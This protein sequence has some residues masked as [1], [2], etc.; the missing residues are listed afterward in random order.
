MT[1]DKPEARPWRLL[2]ALGFGSVGK[3]AVDQE[4]APRVPAAHAILARCV[5]HVS[6]AMA[7]LASAEPRDA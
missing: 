7:G 5:C 1:G 4:V 3:R 2:A 6:G